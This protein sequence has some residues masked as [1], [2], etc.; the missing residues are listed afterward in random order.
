MLTEVFSSEEGTVEF[1]PLGLSIHVSS[2][3]PFVIEWEEIPEVD[4]PQTGDNSKITLWFAL[5]TLAGTAI[6]ALKRKAV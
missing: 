1:L 6:L 2:L 3:S 5:L 4:L